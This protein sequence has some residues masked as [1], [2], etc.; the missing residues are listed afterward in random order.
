[1]LTE[2][3]VL[4]IPLVFFFPAILVADWGLLNG[5][6]IADPDKVW[7]VAKEEWD[8][9]YMIFHQQQ[10][11]QAFFLHMVLQVKSI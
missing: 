10:L 6:R 11:R 1:M 3:L 2:S 9:L 5:N 8:D 4:L 7:A